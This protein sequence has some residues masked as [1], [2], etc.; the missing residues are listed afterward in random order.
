MDKHQIADQLNAGVAAATIDGYSAALSAEWSEKSRQTVHII[1]IDLYAAN[2][3]TGLWGVAGQI[4]TPTHKISGCH[5][6][7]MRLNRRGECNE[8][9]E[10]I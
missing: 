9:G 10:Q 4:E 8:C 6:C 2:I 3:L 5:W 7:G 1:G